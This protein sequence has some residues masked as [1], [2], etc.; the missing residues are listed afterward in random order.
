M[1]FWFVIALFGIFPAFGQ[2][3]HVRLDTN[4]IRIGEQTILH[5]WFDYQN[6]REDAL[7]GWPQVDDQLTDEIEIIDKTVDY[8]SLLDSSTYTYRREQQLTISAFEPGKFRIPPFTIELNE[9]TFKTPELNLLVETVEVDTS[10]GIVDI[11]PIYQVEYSFTEMAADWFKKYWYILAGIATAVAIFFLFRLLRN[12]K[13]EE[14]QPEAPKIP[15]HITALEKLNS[16]IV[17]ERWRDEDKKGFYSELTDTVRR[18]LEE[19]FDI[20]AMEQTTNEI[21]Q[22][23][24]NA[25]LEDSD[26]Q[27]LK[28]ILNRADLV[29]FAKFKPA[30]EDGFTSLHQSIEF[31][32]KTKREEDS[33]ESTDNE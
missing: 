26:K 24:K 12:R 25:D 5:V 8:E 30:E 11:K 17:Q 3:A 18:Y 14:P 19:R 15:A 22:N 7:I 28:K 21:I 13:K 23:L 32:N 27:Y 4:R 1:K 10:K 2:E 20:Y 16:L 9:D 29:K 33:S 31:V 6:P